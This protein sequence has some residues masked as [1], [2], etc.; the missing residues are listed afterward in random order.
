M[1]ERLFFR[2]GYRTEFEARILERR[3]HEGRPAVVLDKTCFY[4]ESGGQ[5]WDTGTL[6]GAPV[7]QVVEEG[8]S[9]LH[10][11]ADESGPGPALETGAAVSGRI[12][13]PRRFDHMQQHTGQHILSQA[14]IEVLNGETRSFHLGEAASTLEIGLS[15]AE[16][17]DIERVERRANE[18]V[19]RDLEVKTYF[20][21]AENI[22][23]IPLRRP[24]K[25]EGTI[26]V[27]EVEGFDYSACGGTHCRRTGEIGLIKVIRWDKIRGNLRFEFLCG[28]RALEDYGRR[29]AALRR[30]SGLFSASDADAP[31][32]VEKALGEIKAQNKAAK[33]LREKLAACEAQDLIRETEG[34]VIRRVFSDKTPEEVRLL[35]LA[36]IR[37]ASR[38]VLFA[39]EAS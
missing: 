23:Q 34:R 31:A 29:N 18:I 4:P 28:G 13:W 36:V 38:I 30:I 25:K 3:E 39:A 32:S 12:D 26:R 1:T 22:G 21:N 15:R 5:P 17:A 8:E 11:L 35:A 16:D 6:S 37:Q 33:A 7:V 20:V 2:D 9:I 10:V 24:P 19:F 14:F 27:V